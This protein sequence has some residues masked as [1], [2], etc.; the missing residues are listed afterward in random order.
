MKLAGDEFGR[1]TFSNPPPLAVCC[2]RDDVQTS[3]VMLAPAAG[4][5]DSRRRR[6]ELS[7][8]MR[9]PTLGPQ[10]EQ[11]RWSRTGVY[12]RRSCP[13]ELCGRRKRS[14]RF[15]IVLSKTRFS[16]F[17]R[18][19][20]LSKKTKTKRLGSFLVPLSAGVLKSLPLP[21]PPGC[22]PTHLSSV[23][24]QDAASLFVCSPHAQQ[25]RRRDHRTQELR[26]KAVLKS[27]G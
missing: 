2:R 3:A 21:G 6:S 5:R 17:P 1:G 14:G 9:E 13:H 22:R 27:C 7:P 8:R 11:G 23:A 19:C 20:C 18:V 15:L 26:P 12:T 4:S 16:H 24:K 10:R 25:L